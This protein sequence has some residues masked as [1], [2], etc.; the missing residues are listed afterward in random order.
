MNNLNYLEKYLKYKNKYDKLKKHNQVTGNFASGGAPPTDVKE[1]L[2]H[3]DFIKTKKT[4]DLDNDAYLG[5]VKDLHPKKVNYGD[6][7]IFKSLG[8]ENIKY[9]FLAFLL[10]FL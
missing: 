8:I 4:L 1:I 9:Y 6:I 7:P 10:N 5:F 3:E 2:V